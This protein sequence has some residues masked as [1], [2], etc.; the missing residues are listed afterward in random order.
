MEVCDVLISM[1]GNRKQWI[2]YEE[3]CYF[4]KGNRNFSVVSLKFLSVLHLSLFSHISAH[5]LEFSSFLCTKAVYC[6]V[7]LLPRKLK[8]CKTVSSSVLSLAACA[9]LQGK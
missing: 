8:L 9:K 3:F 5:L 4:I 7:I 6:R 2:N 1:K